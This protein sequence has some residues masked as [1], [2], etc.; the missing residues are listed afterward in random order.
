MKLNSELIVLI[1]AANFSITHEDGNVWYFGK[2]SSAGQDFGFSIVTEDTLE[3]FANN[4][5]SY[6]EDFDVSEEAYIWLDS[7]GHG[8]NGAP[9]EMVD[10]YKDM[11]ECAEYI[12]ELYTIVMNYIGIQEDETDT[13]DE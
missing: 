4:V 3:Q 13:D 12:T 10:V 7:S 2:Y 5:R 8:K 9:Y 11:E 6:Y 1:E